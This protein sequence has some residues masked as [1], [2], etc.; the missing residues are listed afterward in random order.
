MPALLLMKLKNGA[1]TPG[2]PYYDAIGIKPGTR[3]IVFTDGV[4]AINAGFTVETHD[5]WIFLVFRG[6]LPPFKGDFWAWIDDWLN[7][8]RIGPMDWKA[9]GKTIGKVE[10]GFGS[11]LLDLWSQVEKALSSY[12]IRSKKG[13]IV[14]GHSKGAGMTFLASSLLKYAH[15]NVLIENCAFAAPMTCDRT[16]RDNYD[17]LGLRP[18]TVSYQN[19]YDVVPFL[20][21]LPYL[22]ALVTTERLSL[23]PDNLV[24]TSESWGVFENEYMLVG[25]LRYLGDGCVTEYGEK[26]QSDADAAILSALEGLHF[27]EIADAHSATGRYHKCICG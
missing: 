19:K 23:G 16:F 22:A 5:G 13:I 7:D 3:P 1:I 6:T 15:P 12:D 27:E 4:E 17:A 8:F 26:G 20:P 10:T 21:Y 14:T 2:G 18:F 9:G 24:I 11:A 25:I